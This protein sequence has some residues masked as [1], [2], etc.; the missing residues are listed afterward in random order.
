[1]ALGGSLGNIFHKNGDNL[2]KKA[3]S[4]EGNGLF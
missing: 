4:Q 3:A 2:W 1:M